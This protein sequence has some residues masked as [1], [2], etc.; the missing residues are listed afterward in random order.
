MIV[1]PA[2][3]LPYS[4]A[5]DNVQTPVRWTLAVWTA[6]P[7]GNGSDGAHTSQPAEQKESDNR[8]FPFISLVQS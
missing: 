5:E 4:D 7:N 3:Y 2:S 1:R 6:T 8:L